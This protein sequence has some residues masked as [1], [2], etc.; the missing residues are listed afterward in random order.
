MYINKTQLHPNI[1]FKKIIEIDLLKNIEFVYIV[2]LFMIIL[3]NQ[4]FA[5]PFGAL[6]FSSKICDMISAYF[7]GSGYH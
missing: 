7:N 1:A 3:V 2:N 5:Y 4:F 6:Y